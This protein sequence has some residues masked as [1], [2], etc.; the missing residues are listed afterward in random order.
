MGQQANLYGP[1]G[2]GKT[3]RLTGIADS[4]VRERGA[5]ALGAVTFT[6]TAAGELKQRLAPL[7]GA[8]RHPNLDLVFPHVGTIHSLCYRLIG[9]PKV[10][11]N[12]QKAEWAASQGDRDSEFRGA[13]RVDWLDTYDV[14]GDALEEGDAQAALHI[15]GAARQQMLALD[16]AW[17]RFSRRS[18]MLPSLE[19]VQRLVQSYSGYKREEQVIDFEDMLEEGARERL[20]VEY[21]LVDEAQD[22]SALLWHVI[23]SWRRSVP[24][25]IAAGDPWQAIFLFN[26]ANPSIFRS[27]PG[28]WQTIDDSHRLLPESAD[29]ALDVLRRGGYG[30][31]SLL[32]TWKGVGEGYPRDG[33]SLYLARTGAQVERLAESLIEQGTPFAYLSGRKG[34]LGA[35]ATAGWRGAYELLQEGSAPV[36]GVVAF[37]KA[38]QKG[39]LN[40]PDEMWLAT[41]AREQPDRRVTVDEL[42]W[43]GSVEF[44]QRRLKHHPY[45][46][47]IVK[48]YG[49]GAL[50]MPPAAK[51]GT[52]HSAKGREADHVYLVRNWG[53]LP[54]RAM[55]DGDQG[56]V[57][58]AYVGV[59]RH[60]VSL[61]LLD[62]PGLFGINYP[63]PLEGRLRYRPDGS[64]ER[65]DA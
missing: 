7:V 63:F 19:R 40:R 46:Q 11:T 44:L 65:L 27:Q 14:G 5:G 23:E 43:G 33:T 22:N 59:S 54:G 35:E 29:F 55:L 17:H 49:L 36:R 53:I 56:E 32:G 13:E 24:Y 9:R 52:I 58:V 39:T 2:S 34:P 57:C 50:V 10:I 3:R 37:A 15:W 1:P 25:V 64:V 51:I 21:L 8:E 47:R 26:G 41:V 61:T 62:P 30:E 16:E 20:P 60:R 38:L 48:D 6:R 28:G 45:Y 42:P 31:D 4:V 18:P 12:R